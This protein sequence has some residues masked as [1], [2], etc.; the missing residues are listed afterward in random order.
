MFLSLV[1][2][3]VSFM[4]LKLWNWFIKF[5]YSILMNWPFSHHRVSL[6]WITLLVLKSTLSNI[7]TTMPAFL[8]FEFPLYTFSILW[9]L[10]AFFACGWVWAPVRLEI[11]LCSILCHQV[12]E[13]QGSSLCFMVQVSVCEFLKLLFPIG[14]I[15]AFCILRKMQPMFFHHAF[16]P[17]AFR[18]PPL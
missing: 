3:Y 7:N 10:V 16:L 4:Y 8:P 5:F 15:L 12:S 18:R 14:P 9:V 6:S 17:P 1:F 2:S 13:P 11:P